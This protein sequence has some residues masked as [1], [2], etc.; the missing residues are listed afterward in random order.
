MVHTAVPEYAIAICAETA[1]ANLG[2]RLY[3]DEAHSVVDVRTDSLQSLRELGP[4]DLVHLV[5]QPSKSTSK[6]VK[7]RA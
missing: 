1:R 6:Q 3:E 4:P 7:S 2:Y 5:K